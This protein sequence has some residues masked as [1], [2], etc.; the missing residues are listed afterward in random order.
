[1]VPPSSRRLPAEIIFQYHSYWTIEDGESV[2]FPVHGACLDILRSVLA[3]PGGADVD[4]KALYEA[5]CLLSTMFKAQL[6]VDYGKIQGN[7]SDWEYIPGEEVS[8]LTHGGL[9]K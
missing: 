4:K 9:P 8:R 1:M 5:M 6:T 3:A 2:V 7:A